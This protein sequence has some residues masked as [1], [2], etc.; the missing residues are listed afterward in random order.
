[1]NYRNGS[2]LYFCSPSP[3]FIQLYKLHVHVLQVQQYTDVI[4]TFC[5]LISF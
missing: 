1:M 4:I 2:P 5:N 3:F